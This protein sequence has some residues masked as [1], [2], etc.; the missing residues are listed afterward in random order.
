MTK[1]KWKI[2][3]N[4]NDLH[5][6]TTYIGRRIPLEDNCHWKTTSIG[7]CFSLEDNLHWKMT[8]IGRRLPME[9]AFHRKTTSIEREPQ[10]KDDLKTLK[11]EYLLGKVSIKKNILFMEFSIMVR[12]PPPPRLWRKNIFPT[13][14]F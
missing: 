1:P 11:V 10:I 13:Y 9:D 12:H 7:R 14:D 6:N 4:E 8:A 5:C 2:V 3:W